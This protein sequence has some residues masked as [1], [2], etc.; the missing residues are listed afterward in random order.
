M[1][2]LAGIIFLLLIILEQKIDVLSSRR[3]PEE[4]GNYFQGDIIRKSN[5]FK[6]VIKNSEMKWPNG[7]IRYKISKIYNQSNYDMIRRAMD[8]IEYNT[9]KCIQFK[10][11][12]KKTKDYIFILD[13]ENYGCGS[14]VGRQK[15]KQD[16]FL[17]Q[18]ICL[19]KLGT[20][21]HELLHAVGLFHEHVRP[22][23]DKYVRIFKNNI[24]TGVRDNFEIEDEE[25]I[26][27][28]FDYDYGSIMHYSTNSFAKTIHLNTMRPRKPN[29]VI[30]QRERLSA[31]DIKKLKKKKKKMLKLINSQIKLILIIVVG[32]FVPPL[33]TFTYQ[34]YVGDYPF[35]IVS[36]FLNSK[37]Q[38]LPEQNSPNPD[39]LGSYIEGDIVLSPEMQIEDFE[40]E[41]KPKLWSD[42]KIPYIIS[43][44]FYE[45]PM[46]L[47]TI[48]D[49]INDFHLLT[50]IQFVPRTTE[51][52]YVEIKADSKGC[53]SYVGKQGFVQTVNLQI[54]MC[55]RKKG[56]VIH[57]FMHTIGFFHEHRRFER[58]FYI[59]VHWD[60]IKDEAQIHFRKSM[61]PTD[62]LGIPYDYG[63]VMHYSQLAFSKNGDATI[64]PRMITNEV[65]GQRY[66]FSEKDVQKVNTMYSCPPKTEIHL[67]PNTTWWNSIRFF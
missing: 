46:A 38:L 60:N 50:C 17:E 8:I 11:K 4:H 49:A 6:S 48:Y 54:P 39:E 43:A 33:K 51:S 20:I 32:I 52:D 35:S 26:R 56:T 27:F 40:S 65:L 45:N 42:K 18:P 12:K 34:N 47:K 57:E 15:G 59:D 22:D 30:G 67:A 61:N 13:K 2:L 66:G 14:H 5:L 36:Y 29:I 7:I 9:N 3:N 28:D 31:T 64:L 53:W 63:S 37:N 1:N 16:L 58:D 62:D 55:L 21:I 25:N 41:K 44:E 10:G 23:R 19:E 24:K